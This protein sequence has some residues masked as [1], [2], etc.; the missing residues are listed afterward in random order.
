MKKEDKSLLIDSLVETLKNYSHFYLVDMTGLD[1]S[2]TSALRRKCFGSEVK[3]QM[4]KNTLFEKALE[5]LDNDF[6][7]LAEC[8][9]G[10]TG[11]MLCNTANVPAKLIKEFAKDHNDK[12]ALKGAYAEE[13]F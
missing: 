5:R 12:P 8:L 11:L 3:L 10:T 9:K 4:V 6:S 2:T 13:S 1:S 7:P